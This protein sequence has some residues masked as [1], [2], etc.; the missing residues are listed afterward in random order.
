MGVGDQRC[1]VHPVFGEQRGDRV[2]VLLFAPE[3]P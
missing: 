3:C 2:G 1:V